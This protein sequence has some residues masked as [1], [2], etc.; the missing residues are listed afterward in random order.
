MNGELRHGRLVREKQDLPM[1]VQ[2][3]SSYNI[4]PW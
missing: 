2:L 3:I 1:F 4:D